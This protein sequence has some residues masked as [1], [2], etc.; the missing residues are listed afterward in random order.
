MSKEFGMNQDLSE[1]TKKAQSPEGQKLLALF[2]SH[3]SDE[4]Q[5][6]LEQAAA[7]DFSNA[8]KIIQTILADKE[9]AEL[10]DKLRDQ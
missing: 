5:Q 10:V 6:A 9:A 3:N 7:G 4:M 8:K 1:L 2:Q